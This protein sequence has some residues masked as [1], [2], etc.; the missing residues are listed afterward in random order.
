LRAN[1]FKTGR[2][3]RAQSPL[4]LIDRDGARIHQIDAIETA[5]AIEDDLGRVHIHD[6]DIAAENR[7][8]AN[9]LEKS[10]NDEILST[11]GGENRQ[12]VAD[13]QTVALGKSPRKQKRVRLG[14]VSERIGD[15]GLGAV[16]LVLA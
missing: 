15:F 13:A 2:Q 5:T 9:G 1:G 14:K 6:R 3:A 16:E 12:A 11:V 10:L 4:Q 7:A 8:D